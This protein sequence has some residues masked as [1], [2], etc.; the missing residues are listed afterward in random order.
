M[1]DAVRTRRLGRVLEVTLDRPPANAIDRAAK[2]I[3]GRTSFIASDMREFTTADRFDVIVFNESLYYVDDPI[4]E[5]RRYEGFM[6]GAAI[7][8]ISMHRKAKSDAIW[9]GIKSREIDHVILRNA[10]GVEWIVGAFHPNGRADLVP[11]GN[12]G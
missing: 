10:R 6:N 2:R 4:G 7:F 1:D 12:A 5:L 3:D 11:G 9:G 8:L